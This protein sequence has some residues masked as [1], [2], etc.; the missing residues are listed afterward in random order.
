MAKSEH[1]AG[2]RGGY[3]GRKGWEVRPWAGSSADG[4]RVPQDEFPAEPAAPQLPT[5][6]ELEE[7]MWDAEEPLAL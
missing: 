6:D 5:V 7:D 3:Q 4:V 1:H 2:I